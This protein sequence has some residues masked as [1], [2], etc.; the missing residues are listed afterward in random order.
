MAM[1][2]N[3][4]VDQCAPQVNLGWIEAI[5]DWPCLRGGLGDSPAQSRDPLDSEVGL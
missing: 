5:E 4:R 3:H 2:N 1:L